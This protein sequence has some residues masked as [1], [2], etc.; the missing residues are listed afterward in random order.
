LNTSDFVG[1]ISPGPNLFR[2]LGIETDFVVAHLPILKDDRLIELV[3]AVF[4]VAGSVN[5]QLGDLQEN[6]Q[7]L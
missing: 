3:Q 4:R 5:P 1:K 2:E 7:G 6:P